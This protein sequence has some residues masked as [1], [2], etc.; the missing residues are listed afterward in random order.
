MVVFQHNH[1]CYA[2]NA[3]QKLTFN[4]ALTLCKDMYPGVHMVDYQ[5]AAEEVFVQ[6]LLKSRGNSKTSIFWLYMPSKYVNK[7]VYN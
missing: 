5:D 7:K 3:T 6:T 2:V 1:H 4:D